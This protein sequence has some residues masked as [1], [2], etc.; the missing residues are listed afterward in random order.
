MKDLPVECG[1]TETYLELFQTS[2]KDFLYK[3]C[4]KYRNFT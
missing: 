2:A 4:E 1:N 3:H